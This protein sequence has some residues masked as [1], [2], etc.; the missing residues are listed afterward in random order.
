MPAAVALSDEQL[1]AVLNAVADRIGWSKPA[2]QGISRGIAQIMGGIKGASN[3]F[4]T[5]DLMRTNEDVYRIISGGRVIYGLP[6]LMI[7]VGQGR[8]LAGLTCRSRTMA[9]FKPTC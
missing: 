9:A 7:Y 1:A 5:Y 8:P 4:Q 3:P 2:P 6:P